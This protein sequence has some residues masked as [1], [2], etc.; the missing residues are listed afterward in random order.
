MIEFAKFVSPRE[1]RICKSCPHSEALFPS[2][3]MIA[4]LAGFDDVLGEGQYGIVYS[5]TYGPDAVAIKAFKLPLLNAE[6]IFSA[7]TEIK[8]MGYIGDH[9]NIVKFHGVDISRLRSGRELQN[10]KR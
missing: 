4:I 10:L 8:L 6:Q 7:L 1:L 5:G 9:P 2:V 3:T